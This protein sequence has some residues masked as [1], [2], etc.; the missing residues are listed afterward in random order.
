MVLNISWKA[1]LTNKQLYGNLPKLTE[2]V[3]ERRLQLAGHCVRH[4]DE[5]AHH[6]VLWEP[7]R[8]RRNRRRGITFIDN[9]KEDTGLECAGEL[10][11]MMNNRK[12]W[13]KLAHLDLSK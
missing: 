2:I 6:L 9:L 12:V 1:K 4:E 8:R 13:K 3:K 5:I 7:T 11:V 10:K